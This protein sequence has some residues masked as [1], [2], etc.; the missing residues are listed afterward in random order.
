M[1]SLTL[2]SKASKT[3]I[4]SEKP[5][6][7]KT[8]APTVTFVLNCTPIISFKAVLKISPK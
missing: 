6:L 5:Y 7:L 4:K 8:V 3:G 1:K 2:L